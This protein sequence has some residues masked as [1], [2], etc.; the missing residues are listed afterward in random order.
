[1]RENVKRKAA[2]CQKEWMKDKDHSW[3]AEKVSFWIIRN[4][5]AMGRFSASEDSFWKAKIA[6][7]VST[8]LKFNFQSEYR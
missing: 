6:D 3:A 1:M 7:K 5:A 8:E 2:K 4:S